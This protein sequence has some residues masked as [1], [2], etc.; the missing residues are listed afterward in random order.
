MAVSTGTIVWISDIL[1]TYGYFVDA[2]TIFP[3]HH[4]A[5]IAS[6]NP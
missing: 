4:G 5:L 6:D 2:L 1:Q 3:T